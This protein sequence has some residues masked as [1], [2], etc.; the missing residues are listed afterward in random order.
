[1]TDTTGALNDVVLFDCLPIRQ[2]ISRRDIV[3]AVALAIAVG[4]VAAGWLVAP[5]LVN[6]LPIDEQAVL[7][8]VSNAAIVL[9]NPYGKLV[10]PFGELV[11][12]KQVANS[13]PILTD[14]SFAVDLF[15]D[16]NLSQTAD[17]PPAVDAAAPIQLPSETSQNVPLPP[18]RPPLLRPPSSR[19]RLVP[20]ARQVVVQ[21]A[22]PAAATINADNRNFLQ[23]LFD[24]PQQSSK[25]ALAYAQPEDGAI[26][27]LPA[28]GRASP[29][30]SYDRFTAVYDVQAHTVYLPN[31]E[32]LEA[33][34]GLGSMLDDPRYVNAKDRGATP[35]HLYDLE[36]R[37]DLFHGV[38]ALRLDPVGDG[39][40]YGRT[41]LLAHTFMLGPNGDSNGC[42]SF[43]DYSKFLQAYMNGDVKHLAV[44]A[45]LI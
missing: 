20:A 17:A 33:H 21:P 10:S 39:N 16:S 9:D 32:R 42:V 14:P 26:N 2:G 18:A 41:G 37:K 29:S 24:L 40:M 36:L 27:N 38:Q 23:K 44:V 6:N 7:S 31:G 13:A 8:P 43:K 35:P 11:G 45:H 28:F 4:A 12:A 3:A 19:E 22:K 25:N 15:L 5:S 34:S 30:A 1:M